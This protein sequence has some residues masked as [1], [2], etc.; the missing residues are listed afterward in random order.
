MSQ[1]S[2]SPLIGM[3]ASITIFAYLMRSSVRSMSDG[4]RKR[5]IP[6]LRVTEPSIVV[7]ILSTIP[8]KFLLGRSFSRGGHITRRSSMRPFSSSTITR[9]FCTSIVIFLLMSSDVIALPPSANRYWKRID[10]MSFA[11]SS[12]HEP[13]PD[14][15]KS[16]SHDVSLT[17]TMMFAALRSP[18]RCQW[19]ILQ[20]ASH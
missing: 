12:K 20:S 16:I 1:I 9:P 3:K 11:Q 18:W 4:L 10:E 17:S 13:T 19:S 6:S 5:P 7:S 8:L 2:V 15:A 14:V